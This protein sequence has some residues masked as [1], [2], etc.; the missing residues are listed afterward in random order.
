MLAAC[1]PRSPFLSPKRNKMIVWH[2]SENCK[3]NF[4]DKAEVKRTAWLLVRSGEVVCALCAGP[5]TVH[6]CYPRHCRDEEGNRHYGWIA[7][8]YCDACKVYPALIPSFIKPNKH[9]KADVI[10][11]V[12][13]EAEAG[14]NVEGLSGCAAD[15]STMRR[16]VKDFK[17]R[18]EQAASCLIS[19]LPAAHNAHILSLDLHGMT[20]LQKL[21]RLLHEY[22][23]RD[24]GGVI[25]NANIILTT[26]NCG[27]L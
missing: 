20:L 1:S 4:L 23:V 18:G 27:F 25:G 16:W 22:P 2:S 17:E 19:K 12:I 6:G 3:A 21:A 14:G 26:Q 9:Y 5:L 7:Q 8:G 24:G 10:E 15:A 13:E 11:R